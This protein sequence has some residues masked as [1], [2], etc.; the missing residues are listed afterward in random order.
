MI[1]LFPH[2]SDRANG[3]HVTADTG[4]AGGTDQADHGSAEPL[5]G[6]VMAAVGAERRPGRPERP[7]VFTN[8]IASADGGTAV[9]GLSGALGGDGDLAMFQALRVQADVI[10][11][12][13]ETARTEQYRPP[14]AYSQGHQQRRNRGQRP[15]PRL[16]LLSN[17]LEL[18]PDLPLF[19]EDEDNRPLILTSERSFASRGSQ[20][21]DLATVLPVGSENVDLAAAI[22][23][24]G[25]QGHA[26]ILCEGGPSINGQ[27]VA[28]GLIHEWNLTIAPLLASGRSKRAA[29]GPLVEGPPAG[30]ELTR[31]WMEDHYLFCRWVTTS[32]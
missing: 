1:Q 7:W 30:M 8:M 10:L 24:L 9:D 31:V 15:R 25:Q 29:V 4:A 2:P 11:V 14:M 17:S 12:G 6:D 22:T 13:G 5:V 21:A 19:D 23:T 27:L 26:R 18:D 20:L 28:A 16:V 3:S 32:A